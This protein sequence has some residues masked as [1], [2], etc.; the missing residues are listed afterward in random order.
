MQK[1]YKNIT[2]KK[3]RWLRTT[4]QDQG[5]GLGKMSQEGHLVSAPTNKGCLKGGRE[6]EDG[7]KQSSRTPQA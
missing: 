6:M 3:S 1:H 2:R 4:E 7:T 5:M